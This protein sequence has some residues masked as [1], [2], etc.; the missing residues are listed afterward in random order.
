MYEAMAAGRTVISA[1]FTKPEDS[2]HLIDGLTGLVTESKDLNILASLMERTLTEPELRKKLG[3]YAQ[4]YA[5][6]AFSAT[7]MAKATV[8][9]YDSLLNS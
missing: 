6:S 8:K 5:Q 1:G 7:T 3:K 2:T 9:V 4:D